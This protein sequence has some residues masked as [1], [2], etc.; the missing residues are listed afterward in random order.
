M[1]GKRKDTMDIREIL[2]RLRKGQSDRVSYGHPPLLSRVPDD[3]TTCTR[4]G[5][6]SA[7]G[8]I[9]TLPQDNNPAHPR[10][11]F[12]SADCYPL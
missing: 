6:L 7:V 10:T 8:W 1:P 3:L 4:P 9:S 2:R 12:C 5:Q 11:S